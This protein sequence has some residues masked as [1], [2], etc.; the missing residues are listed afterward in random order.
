MSTT[1]APQLAHVAVG[2]RPCDRLDHGDQWCA[3]LP[4]GMNL[5]FMR[6]TAIKHPTRRLGRQPT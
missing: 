2:A 4:S 5:N 1:F 6:E 3:A